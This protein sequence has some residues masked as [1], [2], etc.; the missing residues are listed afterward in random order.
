MCFTSLSGDIVTPER[1]DL[2]I[3]ETWRLSMIEICLNG[4]QLY[5]FE[6]YSFASPGV[7]R[8]FWRDFSSVF[9]RISMICAGVSVSAIITSLRRPRDIQLFFV[10][11][12]ILESLKQIPLGFSIDLESPCL[13]QMIF[14]FLE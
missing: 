1:S 4:T 3:M 5:T 6:I 12:S 2:R 8:G 9:V 13:F 10:V 14:I 11:S 7:G